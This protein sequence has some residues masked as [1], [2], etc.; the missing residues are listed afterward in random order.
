M[1]RRNLIRLIE[2]VLARQAI[3][4][5][6]VGRESVE[7]FVEGE[8]GTHRV[9]V[10]V[11]HGRVMTVYVDGDVR[12]S[13]DRME[14]VAVWVLRANETLLLGNFELALDDGAIRF[15]AG[16]DAGTLRSNALEGLLAD[17]WLAAAGIF[18]RHLPE[19]SA[20]IA[21]APEGEPENQ[22]PRGSDETGPAQEDDEDHDDLGPLY[23][24]LQ[25]DLTQ[26]L[27]ELVADRF[28]EDVA[29]DLSGIVG[30][31]VE[32]FSER[33]YGAER[34]GADISREL[35]G[36]E[37]EARLTL[38]AE[39]V[40]PMSLQFSPRLER[41]GGL[42]DERGL[43]LFYHTTRTEAESTLEHG[44]SAA[45]RELMA[46]HERTPE[47]YPQGLGRKRK[48]R[49]IPLATQPPPLDDR[50]ADTAVLRIEWGADATPLRGYE[51]RETAFGRT[52]AQVA[53]TE[54]RRFAVPCSLLNR[55]IRDGIARITAVEGV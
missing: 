19:V 20:V 55:A 36:D 37:Q 43:T 21:A 33:L 26:E 22:Q 9:S 38:G 24:E 47:G 15:K 31:F 27:L 46:D 29:D 49:R 52:E 51:W 30:S 40:E 7:F 3:E 11:A 10:H 4:P 12:A 16:L 53:Y 14:P 8:H 17:L 54:V 48:T 18:D 34:H 32:L 13:L 44:F 25:E 28:G 23:A 6:A 1:A 42:E 5:S 45:L 50:T 35:A 2:R 41:Q 39:G